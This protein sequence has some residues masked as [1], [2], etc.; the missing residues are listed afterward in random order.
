MPATI[1]WLMKAQ[2][3]TTVLTG[4]CCVPSTNSYHDV[5]FTVFVCRGLLSGGAAIEIDVL[6]YWLLTCRW[7]RHLLFG[8][9][10]P[11]YVVVAHWFVYCCLFKLCL[12]TTVKIVSCRNYIR[13]YIWLIP[14]TT[15]LLWL[16]LRHLLTDA[17]YCPSSRW[18]MV[19]KHCRV[20]LLLC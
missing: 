16:V 12:Y 14:N 7:R 18:P 6:P 13:L 4:I 11:S 19:L 20:Y 15:Y 9:M 17:D 10:L 1:Q 5:S 2:L 8:I 3:H